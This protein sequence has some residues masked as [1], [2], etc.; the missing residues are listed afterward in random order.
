MCQ[1][2]CRSTP[3]RKQHSNLGRWLVK[4]KADPN[5][6]NKVI[7][8]LFGDKTGLVFAEDEAEYLSWSGKDMRVI[9]FELLTK[10]L[11]KTHTFEFLLQITHVNHV[12]INRHMV[13]LVY[14]LVLET[15]SVMI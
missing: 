14:T 5:I 9:G 6:K 3:P 4:A 8:K 2:S 10:Q 7:H 15:K 1:C 11:F 13:E 12:V